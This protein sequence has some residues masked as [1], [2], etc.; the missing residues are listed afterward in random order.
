MDAWII[1]R[2]G[3][4]PDGQTQLTLAFA[5]F[6]G[7]LY[8]FFG[9]VLLRLLLGLTGFLLAGTVAALL[10]AYAS[11]GQWLVTLPI[12]IFGGLCGAM[13]L[14][15]LFRLAIFGIGTAGA[16]VV[17]WEFVASRPE[18]WAPWAAVGLALLGGI[19]AVLLERTVMAL[20]TAAL[21]GWMTTRAGSVL[22]VNGLL[23]DQADA[24]GFDDRVFWGEIVVWGVLAL[25]GAAFQIFMRRRKG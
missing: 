18:A 4:L 5:A 19:A 21:G 12:A 2:L 22:L 17:A 23:R 14:V 11:G 6:L 16:G 7:L 13:A 15:F 24:P 9:Y 1:A 20:A 10:A 8:C 3:E 25:L